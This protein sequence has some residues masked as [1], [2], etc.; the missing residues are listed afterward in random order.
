MGKPKSD[1]I[2]EDG[3]LAQPDGMEGV[4]G[5][6]EA[7]QST[8]GL[9]VLPNLAWIGETVEVYYTINFAFLGSLWQFIS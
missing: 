5:D 3:D 6:E 9:R 8:R 2:M 1:N 7:K 4:Y